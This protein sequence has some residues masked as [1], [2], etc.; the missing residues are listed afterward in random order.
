M[1]LGLLA[2][3]E[4]V[5]GGDGHEHAE[6]DEDEGEFEQR[7]AA[8]VTDD[9]V[10]LHRFDSFRGAGRIASGAPADDH[11]FATNREIV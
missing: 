7:E 2:L 10:G 4:D 5:D 9:L 11:A 8:G 6:D 3:T 1:D